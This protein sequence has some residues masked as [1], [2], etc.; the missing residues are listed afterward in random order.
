[1]ELAMVGLGRMGAN[2]AE[3]LVRGGHRV[4]GSD[5]SAE[6]RAK[7]ADKGIEP[8]ESLAAAVAALPSPRIVWLMVPAGDLVD[9]L[10]ADLEPLLAADDVVIDGG[11]SLY[12]DSLRR[13]ERASEKGLH[14]VD[15]GTSGGV[16]GLAEGYSMM[17]GGETAVVE[18]LTPLFEA[19]APAPDKGWGHVGPAGAGHFTKMVHNGIE[20][21]LMQAY[22]EGF[23]IM[24]KKTEFGVDLHQVAEIWRHGSV[25]RSWLLDLTADALDKNPGLEGIAPYVSDSGEGRWT[26]AEALELD[27]SAPVITLSLLERLRSREADSFGDKLLAAMRNEFGGHAIKSD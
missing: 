21:G 11:N 15:V 20:Y 26:V 16:W 25:V 22:A 24:G 13:A 23:A 17:V 2:M 19:L 8:A 5:P 3:R 18:A 9:Q 6:A 27:V 10:L 7:A 1:M 12:K 4:V 14:F